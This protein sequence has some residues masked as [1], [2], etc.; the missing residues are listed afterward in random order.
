MWSK[1]MLDNRDK[2]V[3]IEKSILEVQP[4]MYPKEENKIF[5]NLGCG[6]KTAEGFINIDKYVKGENIENYDMYNIPYPDN[7]ADVTY[8][9]HAL[10]HLPTEQ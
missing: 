3:D 1:E 2:V 6:S 8:S 5:L 4:K 9:S 10:E 7:Y